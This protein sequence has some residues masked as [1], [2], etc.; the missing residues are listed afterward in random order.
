MYFLEINLQTFLHYLEK[1]LKHL[2]SSFDK[3]IESQTR[4]YRFQLQC[5]SSSLIVPSLKINFLN[6]VQKSAKIRQ[7]CRYIYFLSLFFLYHMR[8]TGNS[9]A[10]I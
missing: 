6:W 3:I 4:K 5:F 8:D 7:K 9:R 10:Y 2:L 1:L